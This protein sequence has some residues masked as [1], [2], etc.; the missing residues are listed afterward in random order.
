MN[1]TTGLAVGLAINNDN[2]STDILPLLIAL[3]ICLIILGL[4]IWLG[5]R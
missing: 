3:G 2:Q 5:N 1:Y 4:I